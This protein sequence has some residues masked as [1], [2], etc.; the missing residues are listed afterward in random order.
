MALW[1]DDRV[2]VRAKASQEL[3]ELGSITKPLLRQAMKESASAEARIRAREV[4]QGLASP[5]PIARLIGHQAVALRCVYSADGQ[6]L[7]TTARD[8]PV[9]LWDAATHQRKATLT[10][11]AKAP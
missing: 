5:K 4:L 8:G 1:N 7:A 9:L 3:A 10:W 2:T 11:P 6:F